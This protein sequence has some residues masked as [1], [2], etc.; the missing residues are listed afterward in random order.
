MI[1]NSSM[2]KLYA[3]IVPVIMAYSAGGQP[4]PDY[5]FKAR[6]LMESGKNDEAV[7]ILSAAIAKNTDSRCYIM[8]G[9]AFTAAGRYQEA[10]NDYNSANAIE[11]AS[12]SYGLA[13]LYALRGEADKSLGYLEANLDSRYRRSEKEIMLD[14]AFLKIQNTPEWRQFWKKDRFSIPETKIREIRFYLSSGKKEAATD[15]LSE[16][17][18]EYQSDK[19]T[20]YGKALVDYEYKRYQD[21][22]TAMSKIR[23]TDKNNIDFL[24]LLAKSQMAS[25]NPSGAINTYSAI[26]ESGTTDAVYFLRRAESCIKTGEFEKAMKDISRYLEFYP[27]NREALMMAGKTASLSGDNLKSISYFTRNIELHPGDP[28]C[29][30]NRADAYFS[31]KSWELAANDYSMALDL[32]PDIPDAWLNKGIALVNAGKTED[33]C[34]NLRKAYSLGSKKAVPLLNKYCIR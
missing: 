12:A 22:I 1:R 15:V 7:Q 26:I 31:G 23:V 21:V 5:L 19:L 4:A 11:H 9:D 6:A 16:L 3:F 32:K 14:P 10:E 18:R 13:R 24:E 30:I 8:R 34:Y 25:G 29:F 33:G 28:E 20:I 27:E 17:L 2:K